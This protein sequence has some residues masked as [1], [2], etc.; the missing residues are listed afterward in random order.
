MNN[1][2]GN[3]LKFARMTK[4]IKALEKNIYL[5]LRNSEGGWLKQPHTCML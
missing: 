5:I 3:L 1:N 2:N 4:A